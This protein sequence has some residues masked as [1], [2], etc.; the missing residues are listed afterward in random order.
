MKERDTQRAWSVTVPMIPPSVN[1]YIQHARGGH[2]TTKKAKSFQDA[3]GV[4]INQKGTWVT[5]ETF[6]VWIDVTLGPKERMDVDNAAKCCLDVLAACFVMRDEKGRI[7]SDDR[8]T[9]LEVKKYTQSRDQG[10]LTK[11]T[12]EALT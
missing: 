8:V 1:H 5:G 4:F 6:H 2:F 9:H 3:L 10:P 7:L 12:V 11:I